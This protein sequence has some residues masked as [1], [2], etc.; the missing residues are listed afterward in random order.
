MFSLSCQDNTVVLWCSVMKIFF[1]G[2]KGVP[3]KSQEDKTGRERRTEALSTLLAD[4]GHSVY[5]TC[6]KPYVSKN[7]TKF[8]GVKLVHRPSFLPDK[9]GGLFYDLLSVL[10]IWTI[11]PDVVHIQGWRAVI[12]APL[13]VVLRPE[14]TYV[15]T[16]DSWP[17]QRLKVMRQITRWIEGLFDVIT[18]PSRE[19]QHQMLYNFNVRAIYVPDG[20]T[21]N[22]M[23]PLPLKYFGIRSSGYTLTTATN[24]KDIRMVAKAYKRAGGRRKLVVMVEEKGPFKRL[25]REYAFLHFVGELKG[26][27]LYSLIEEAGLIILTGENNSIDTVLR[28]MSAG[29]AIVTTS[30]VGYQEVLGVSAPIAKKGDVAG[31]AEILS[32]LVKDEKTRLVFG[33]KAKKRARAHFTWKRILPEYIELYHYPLLRAVPMDSAVPRWIA[34]E[35]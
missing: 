22:E 21:D 33:R 26:R 32:P 14:T 27:P 6:T 18:V 9:S 5:V 28:T 35:A 17:Q 23:P 7:L 20:Y 13:A 25:G 16:I 34:K 30:D 29:K 3:C 12:L 11:K 15:W 2:Q 8:N 1:I 31:M 19:L 24:A 4:M 10:S